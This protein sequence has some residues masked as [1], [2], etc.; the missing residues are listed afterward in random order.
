M[1]RGRR[2]D[3]IELWVQ[4]RH[5]WSNPWHSHWGYPS[6]CKRTHLS[7]GRDKP[8]Q[9]TYPAPQRPSQGQLGQSKPSAPCRVARAVGGD[10]SVHASGD[11]I[12]GQEWSHTGL[13]AFR[14]PSLKGPGISIRRWSMTTKRRALL[15]WFYFHGSTSV[16]IMQRKIFSTWRKEFFLFGKEF[17]QIRKE[18]FP[19]WKEIFHLHKWISYKQYALNLQKRG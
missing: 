4:G 10:R 17:F 5:Q 19:F 7:Q 13:D 2:W 15:H 18:S 16:L 8:R 11:A 1:N 9:E 3:E 6:G 14:V 12:C